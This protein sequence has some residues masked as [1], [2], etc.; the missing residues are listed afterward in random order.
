[1]NNLA[2]GNDV[3][4]V[5]VVASSTIIIATIDVARVDNLDVDIQALAEA[6]CFHCI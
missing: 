1:M 4:V 2:I 5:V 6:E 3:I